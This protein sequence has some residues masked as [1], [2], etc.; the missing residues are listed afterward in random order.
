M[1]NLLLP[2]TFL[3]IAHVAQAEDYACL[4]LNDGEFDTQKLLIDREAK[5]VSYPTVPIDIW[6]FEEGGNACDVHTTHAYGAIGSFWT[7]CFHLKSASLY[8]SNTEFNVSEADPKSQN[9]VYRCTEI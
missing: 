9:W 8:I 4:W 7:F 5:T 6:T 1:K 3:L 2:L